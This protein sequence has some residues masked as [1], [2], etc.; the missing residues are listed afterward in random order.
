[1]SFIVCVCPHVR[2]TEWVGVCV[3]GWVGRCVRA[4]VCA[5]EVSRGL[6]T[7]SLLNTYILSDVDWVLA[8]LLRVMG[9]RWSN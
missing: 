7:V 5:Y 9:W 4:Y 8:R 2:M 1:M 3:S 6:F